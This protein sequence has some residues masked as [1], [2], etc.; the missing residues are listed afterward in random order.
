MKHLIFGVLLLVLALPLPATAQTAEELAAKQAI[1]EERARESV[2]T[3]E[4][5]L[6]ARATLQAS[7]AR[8]GAEVDAAGDADK[9]S[10]TAELDA[11]RAELAE[12]EDRISVLATGISESEF[13]RREPAQFDLQGELEALVQPF[14]V[15]LRNATEEARQIESTRR[16]L[17]EAETRLATAEQALEALAV[18]RKQA[19]APTLAQD[20]D[21][22]A[23]S[24]ADRA[25]A[26]RTAVAAL[27][28]QLEDLLDQ[29]VTAGTR[30]QSAAKGFFRERGL[31]LLL[32]I[33]AFV[34]VLTVLRLVGRTAGAVAR[35][36]GLRRTFQTRLTNLLFTVFTIAAAFAAMMIVFNLR[37]DWLLL[38]LSSL[39][40]LALIWIGIRMLPGLVEQVTILLNLGSVQEDE[41]LIFNGVPFRVA[42]LDFYT[43][44]VNPVLDGG[45]FT[46]PVREL[47]GLHS[48]PAAEDEPW[49][50]SAKGDWVR[51]TDGNAGQV[52]AQT[53][54]LVVLELLGGAR[55]TYQTGDYL[56]QTPE[57][58]S[59]GFRAEV[60]F[61][62]GYRHQAE[63][64]QAIRDRMLE[65]VHAHMTAFI[66][67]EHVV[68]A[69]VDLL[70]AGASSIDY[71]VEVDVRGSAAER[72]EDIERELAR[73]MVQLATEEGWEIPFQQIVLHQAPAA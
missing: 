37:N 64:P 3:L 42:R 15:M 28:Q 52:V 4:A 21:T 68:T 20:L 69:A 25:E 65:A 66:G 60:E 12:T 19:T 48:R 45:E 29:R 61:G 23:Q 31:S 40:V 35:R 6:E 70:R 18:V 54:E 16:A 46:L 36:R 10:L 51:L 1:L 56:A 32:G 17:G 13:T 11:L 73:Y 47:I 55:V 59:H 9:E 71:E 63:A 57:N 72:F 34:G 22:R 53:P 2:A 33:G 24:W 14:I 41:R 43:D 62:I 67:P 30:V 8:K 50:P 27:N 7:I 49:F 39:I 5:L 38:G 58:L 44:L 26:A